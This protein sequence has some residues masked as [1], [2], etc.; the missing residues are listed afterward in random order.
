MCVSV[1]TCA[2]GVKVSHEVKNVSLVNSYDI[3]NLS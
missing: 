2:C 3:T 1:R